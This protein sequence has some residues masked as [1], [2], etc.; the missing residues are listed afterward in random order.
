MP[1]RYNNNEKKIIKG[2][3]KMLYNNEINLR[4]FLAFKNMPKM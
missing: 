2:K 4:I 3:P 1:Y